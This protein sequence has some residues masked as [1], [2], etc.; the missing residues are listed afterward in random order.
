MSER[1]HSCAPVLPGVG[2]A[3]M[4]HLGQVLRHCSKLLV[5]ASAGFRRVTDTEEPMP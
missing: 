3:T 2:E 4:V 5:R 1:T